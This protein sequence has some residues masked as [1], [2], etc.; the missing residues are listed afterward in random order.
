MLYVYSAFNE[1]VYQIF[2]D[3]D[4][5]NSTVSQLRSI[6]KIGS[7]YKLNSAFLKMMLVDPFKVSRET[8][9][10]VSIFRLV[11]PSGIELFDNFLFN[12]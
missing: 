1:Q 5:H 11:T 10:P 7:K 9:L 12:R 6:V 2:D 4:F 8:G 3:L